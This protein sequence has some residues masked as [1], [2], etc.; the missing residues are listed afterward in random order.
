MALV[1]TP[2]M[3]VLCAGQ[4]RDSA[5]KCV[6]CPE[7]R[8]KVKSLWIHVSPW[9]HTCSWEQCSCLESLGD[10]FWEIQAE[11]SSAVTAP[12]CVP[13][14]HSRF[15]GLT[16]NSTKSRVSSLGSRVG[17][18][19]CVYVSVWLSAW[20]RVSSQ[21]HKVKTDRWAHLLLVGKF[22]TSSDFQKYQFCE[23]QKRFYHLIWYYLRIQCRGFFTTPCR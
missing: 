2:T 22:I 21:G 6:L 19:E 14:L 17:V 5:V 3:W 12:S 1:T 13:I 7:H 18:I 8:R 16:L 9:N 11:V 23:R 15:L 20:G 10:N 4:R